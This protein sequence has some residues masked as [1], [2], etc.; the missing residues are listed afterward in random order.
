MQ[1]VV[2][3]QHLYFEYPENDLTDFYETDIFGNLKDYSFK[4]TSFQVLIYLL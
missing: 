4:C 3:K 2:A 1:N